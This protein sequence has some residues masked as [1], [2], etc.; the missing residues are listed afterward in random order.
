M[1]QFLNYYI[2]Q[3]LYL[4]PSLPRSPLP[5]SRSLL[6]RYSLRH[7][8]GTAW[9]AKQATGEGV[10]VPCFA[11]AEG[12]K[13]VACPPIRERLAPFCPYGCVRSR[14]PLPLRLGRGV[15]SLAARLALAC[16]APHAVPYGWR[17]E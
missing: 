2:L 10:L 13:H 12:A 5:L 1:N 4:Q 15:A 11:Q 8:Y 17:R 16:F 14:A 3:K 9:G 7:P 6:P